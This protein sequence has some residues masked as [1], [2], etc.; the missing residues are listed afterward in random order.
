MLV[1][2]PCGRQRLPLELPDGVKLLRSR[3]APAL[4]DP[5]AAVRQALAAPIGAPPLAA[6][7]QG[8][9][10][11][12]LVVSDQTRPVPNQDLLPP[13]LEA[14]AQAG[15]GPERVTILVATGMHP[16]TQ[17]RQLVEMLGPEIAGAYRVLNHDCRQG[18]ALVERIEGHAIEIDQA[19]LEA[20]LKI[21]TG[22]IEP[23]TFAGFSGGGKAVLP[24]LASLQTMEFMHSYRLVAQPS[25]ASGRLE[26]NLFQDYIRQVVGG[27]GVDFLVNAVIDHDQKLNG[28][29]AGHWLEAHRA[30]CQDSARQSLASLEQPADLIIT[31]GGGHPLDDTFFQANKGLVTAR[32]LSAPGATV[33]L[34]AGCQGGLGGGEFLRILQESPSP[35]DFAARHGRQGIFCKDQ[36]AV[37]RFYQAKEHFGRMLLFAPGLAGPDFELLGL[38]P[39][40]DLPGAVTGLCARAA[41]AAVIP[42][43][44]YLAGHPRLPA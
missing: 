38:T 28:V 27:L 6:L 14:L 32:D 9:R 34:V 16:P 10:D 35:A 44:P 20:D 31:S 26:G 21:L 43:G 17:G 1:H 24:G 11:A 25:L 5:Q 4:A 13:I 12:C 22:L 37:Q 3:P 29:Y 23:H 42:E 18:N 7:A 33:L 41:R 30:G 19:F 40:S 15:L 2:L 39:V 8:R 36:W